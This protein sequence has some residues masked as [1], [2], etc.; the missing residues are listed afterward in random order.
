MPLALLWLVIICVWIYITSSSWGCLIPL[1]FMFSSDGSW[2]LQ[3]AEVFA[4][5][6]QE[7]RLPLCVGY[8]MCPLLF[9]CRGRVFIPFS[10]K[11]MKH[12]LIQ[13]LQRWL[14]AC[15]GNQA[16]I[17]IFIFVSLFFVFFNGKDT[18]KSFDASGVFPQHEI[19]VCFFR[20]EPLL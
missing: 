11:V 1:F 3:Q 17:V 2:R 13:T 8:K 6:C 7:L 20:S 5:L 9:F 12:P 15:M 19:E 14:D 10:L 18:Q 4:L 16:V